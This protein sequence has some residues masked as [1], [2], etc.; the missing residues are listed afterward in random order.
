MNLFIYFTEIR[1]LPKRK[2]DFTEIRTVSKT[3]TDPKP[4]VIV[5]DKSEKD[6][7]NSIIDTKPEDKNVQNVSES[8]VLE[9]TG[10][11]PDADDG[12][13]FPLAM[14]TSEVI[15][16]ETVK[17]KEKVDTDSVSK[18]FSVEVSKTVVEESTQGG[19]A[20]DNKEGGKEDKTENSRIEDSQK[21]EDATKKHGA[22]NEKELNDNIK[23][24]E[25]NDSEKDKETESI[26]QSSKL[27]SDANA[28]SSRVPKQE[29]TDLREHVLDKE[30]VSETTTA[31]EHSWSEAVAQTKLP[32]AHNKHESDTDTKDDDLKGDGEV[33]M[34]KE[35]AEDEEIDM[36]TD[37]VESVKESQKLEDKSSDFKDLSAKLEDTSRDEEEV[38][39]E[40]DTEMPLNEGEKD[41]KDEITTSEAKNESKSGAGGETL[42]EKEEDTKTEGQVSETNVS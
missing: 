19:K 41:I 28:E 6:T 21:T 40:Q 14:E 1:S 3:K 15:T 25:L 38:Q 39:L 9:S 16:K 34:I 10:Q 2:T 8:S 4:D 17:I 29:D 36:E 31:S 33:E 11:I 26:L 5:I 20:I 32:P 12:K 35:K 42:K 23:D 7:S 37:A 22:E 13:K 24:E 18:K 30:A 27:A